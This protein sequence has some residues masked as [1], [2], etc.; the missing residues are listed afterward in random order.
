MRRDLP[1]PGMLQVPAGT[2]AWLEIAPLAVPLVWIDRY[3][4]TN[5]DY[6]SFVDQSGYA[7]ADFWQRPMS[8]QKRR[9]VE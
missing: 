7:E 9:S 4:V 2:Y 3:E 1:I 6:Q 5:A 8:A